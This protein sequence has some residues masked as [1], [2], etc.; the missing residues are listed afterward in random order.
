M[1][2]ATLQ[3]LHAREST[4]FAPSFDIEINE[5]DGSFSYDYTMKMLSTTS[6]SISLT[7]ACTDTFG[8]GVDTQI[9]VHYDTTVPILTIS[10]FTKIVSSSVI[11]FDG[12]LTDSI[13]TPQKLVLRVTSPLNKLYLYNSTDNASI[14]DYD[15]LAGTFS[16]N[17]SITKLGKY[18][19]S[20]TTSACF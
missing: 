1:I 8:N 3:R 12:T 6:S 15:I 14:I 13:D 11:T 17:Y 5:N 20:I 2:S 7:L 18:K 16:V 9:T 19:F 4:F 10:Q